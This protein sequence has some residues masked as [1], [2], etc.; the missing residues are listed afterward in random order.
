MTL[1]CGC[2]VFISCTIASIPPATSSAVFSWLFVPTQTTMTYNEGRKKREDDKDQGIKKHKTFK[3]KPILKKKIR[4]SGI[5]E[6]AQQVKGFA[7]RLNDLS[8]TPSTPWAHMVQSKNR[9]P[10]NSTKLHSATVCLLT[11]ACEDTSK[12]N[13]KCNKIKKKIQRKMSFSDDVG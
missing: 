11:F 5:G 12:I 13:W 3:W 1:A 10:Q 7:K 6:K 4:E 8:S 2:L 9:F